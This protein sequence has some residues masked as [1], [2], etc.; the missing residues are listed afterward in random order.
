M[1]GRHRITPPSS[2]CNFL[3][4]GNPAKIY[5][6]ANALSIYDRSGQVTTDGAVEEF[7]CRHKSVKERVGCSAG[8]CL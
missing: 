5:G 8:N 3:H 6:G 2:A 1:Y 7:Q 4:A